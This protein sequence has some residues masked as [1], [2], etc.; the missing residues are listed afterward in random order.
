[1]SFWPLCCERETI[2]SKIF[3]PVTRAGVF[4]WVNSH[5]VTEISVAKAKISVT[6]SA[7]LLI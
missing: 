7:L 3:V 1:M 4:L 6:G 5:P 2:F